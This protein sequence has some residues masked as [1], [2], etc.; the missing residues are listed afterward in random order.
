MES[1]LLLADLAIVALFLLGIA[2]FRS[3]R[4]ALYGTGITAMALLLAGVAV[5]LRHDFFDVRWLAMGIAAGSTVG[6]VAA[7]RSRM[8]QIPALIALQNGAGGMA[9]FLV[10]LAAL[11]RTAGISTGMNEAAGVVGLSLGGLTFAASFLAANRLSGRQ[12]E[13]WES[14]ARRWLILLLAL[15]IITA[16]ILGTGQDGFNRLALFMTVFVLAGV[17]GLVFAA[18]VGGAD[19]PVLISFLNATSGLAAAFSGL[20]IESRL[21][22]AT[23]AMV[24]ASGS[25]LTL[26]M[27]TA[28]NRSLVQVLW[29]AMPEA[30]EAAGKSQIASP[31]RQA[32][33]GQAVWQQAV[34]ACQ[35]AGSVVIVPG[36]GMALAQAQVEVAALARRLEEQGKQVRFAVHPVA[37]RMPGHMYVLL[38]EAEVP[39]AKLF[40]LAKING[41]FP[42]TDLAIVVGASDV[43]NPAAISVPGTPISNMPIME[44][45][46]ARRVLVFNLDSRPG[47]SGVPN[48]LYEASHAV[49]VWGDARENIKALTD[50]L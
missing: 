10:S 38:A 20:V 8:V 4:R 2:L 22:V 17:L 28:M 45:H 37:G 43:V 27:C 5:F 47:Y 23:G 16:G 42:D 35:T 30:A 25:V 15:A 44:V 21:L 29:K 50:R 39:Y 41:D 3:P 36:Y 7:A 9:A 26:A 46:K 31:S 48:L 32:Q 49:L 13:T 19:M 12:G 34:E 18:G 14:G 6:W 24:G 1:N 11:M 40:D 33:G